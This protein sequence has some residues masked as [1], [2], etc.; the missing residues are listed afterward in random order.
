MLPINITSLIFAVLVV[1]YVANV[2]LRN[3][4]KLWS[5]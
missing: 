4:F 2:T 3:C 1:M 5:F